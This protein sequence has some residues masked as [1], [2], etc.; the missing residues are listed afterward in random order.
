[1]FILLEYHRK[2]LIELPHLIPVELRSIR[3]TLCLI[4]SS[5]RNKSLL[6][7]F[8]SLFSSQLSRLSYYLRSAPLNT[9]FL[10]S[11]L[12]WRFGW[13]HNTPPC[14]G[15]LFYR[16]HIELLDFHLVAAMTLAYGCSIDCKPIT[17]CLVSSPST[18]FMS[19]SSEKS[20]GSKSIYNLTDS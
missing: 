7:F 1:V 5:H 8:Y 3:D 10:K 2:L 19:S 11:P 9:Y 6:L 20:Y 4:R 16:N 18:L 12:C 14:C 15:P 17:I 13:R